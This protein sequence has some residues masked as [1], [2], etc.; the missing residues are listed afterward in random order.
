MRSGKVKNS[1]ML[2]GKQRDGSAVFEPRRH[3]GGNSR[4]GLEGPAGRCSAS[5]V[6]QR[7]RRAGGY[8]FAAP[9]PTFPSGLVPQAPPLV[10]GQLRRPDAQEGDEVRP[11]T[12]GGRPEAGSGVVPGG[13][14]RRLAGCR[15]AAVRRGECSSAGETSN[16]GPS[17]RP[18]GT[19]AATSSRTG[20][21]RR[22]GRWSRK[23]AV[24]RTHVRLLSSQAH[25]VEH[26]E[27][28][29]RT[30]LRAAGVPTEARFKRE[31][32]DGAGP[33]GDCMAVRPHR[34][35]SFR[36]QKSR[37]NRRPSSASVGFLAE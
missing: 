22:R 10:G 17:P 31:A 18:S 33:V 5:S 7:H 34:P 32:L 36:S 29:G 12:R 26:T 28:I 37:R 11:N 1:L 6:G 23:R 8:R 9:H 30:A 20:W 21:S 4:R 2:C 3:R 16:D 25:S 19:A 24:D 13:E 27:K 35:L 14:R 15:R